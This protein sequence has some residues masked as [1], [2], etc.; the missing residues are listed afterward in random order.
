VGNGGFGWAECLGFQQLLIHLPWVGVEPAAHKLSPMK[1]QAF[2]P[3]EATIPSSGDNGDFV[4][5]SCPSPHQLL[6]NLPWVG[7]QPAAQKLSPMKTQAFGP[8]KPTT[9]TS[10]QG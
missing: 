5:A 2:S 4:L 10:G 6:T 8:S 7:V 1:I 9:L 3:S